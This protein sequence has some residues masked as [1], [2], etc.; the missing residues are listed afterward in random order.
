[1]K[2]LVSFVTA[3]CLALTLCGCEIPKLA[4]T[5]SEGAVEQQKQNQPLTATMPPS[6]IQEDTYSSLSNKGSGWGFKRIKGSEPEIFDSTKELFKKYDTYYMDQTKPKALYLTFDE[7]YENGY[8][9]QILDTLKKCNVP[10]AFF[11]TEPYLRQEQD[12]IRRMLDEGHTVGN[13]TVHH[14]N[15]PRL[16]SAKKVEEELSTLNAQFKEVYGQ[17]MKYMRPPEGEYSEKVLAVAKDLGY[18]TIFWSFAYR[19]WDPN[20]QKSAD[21]AFEQVTPYLHDGAILLLH[22]VSRDNAQAL[23]RIINYAKEQG[24]EFRSLDQL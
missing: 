23:E 9:G 12:L 21:Y 18:K 13:H 11:I 14:P 10:A 16:G 4:K 7:G 8:T 5:T 24:Y 3:G 6:V 22:A 17:D 2:K 20:N 19:D 15:M 1:M